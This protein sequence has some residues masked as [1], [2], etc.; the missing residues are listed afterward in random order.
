M[1]F[2][3][4]IE[5]GPLEAPDVNLLPK[6]PKILSS[7]LSPKILEFQP[8]EP[9]SVMLMVKVVYRLGAHPPFGQNT[10]KIVLAR[11]TVPLLFW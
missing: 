7:C 1:L 9:E 2:C 11:N 4:I 8:F 3:T 10:E 6:I 5:T